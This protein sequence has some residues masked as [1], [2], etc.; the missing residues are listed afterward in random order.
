M[1]V[2]G[3]V[4]YEGYGYDDD[5]H[6]DDYDLMFYPDG[7]RSGICLNGLE[8]SV[9]PDYSNVAKAGWMSP[10]SVHD[11]IEGTLDISFIQERVIESVEI[12]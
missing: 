11:V 3:K 2:H 9:W 10:I 12:G 1:K 6:T 8:G 7:E 5:G 4:C